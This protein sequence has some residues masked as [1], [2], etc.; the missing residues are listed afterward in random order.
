MHMYIHIYIYVRIYIYIYIYIHTC[1]Y[2]YIYHIPEAPPPGPRTWRLDSNPEPATYALL[3]FRG[4]CMACDD[5]GGSGQPGEALRFRMMEL[6]PK[7]KLARNVS[8][9]SD[10][11]G[12][13]SHKAVLQ[14]HVKP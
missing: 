14:T 1:V 13:R 11:P 12:V 2:I 9:E 3:E 8:H 5:F 7:L 4:F 10:L 6:P